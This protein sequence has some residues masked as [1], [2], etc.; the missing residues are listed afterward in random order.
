MAQLSYETL[1]APLF[2]QNAINGDPLHPEFG[3]PISFWIHGNRVE[4]ATSATPAPAQIFDAEGLWCAPGFFDFGSQWGIPG[5]E[6]SE[7]LETGWRAAVAGGFTESLV[8]PGALFPLDTAPAWQGFTHRYARLPLTCHV[9]AAI[10]AG[11]TG[12]HMAELRE[13]AG[14][15]AIAFS[16]G[17]SPITETGTLRLA[18]EYGAG[19][20]ALFIHQPAV[21]GLAAGGQVHE[22]MASLLTGLP[23]IPAEEEFLGCVRDLTVARYLQKPLHVQVISS[24]MALSYI[25][26]ARVP[27]ISLGTSVMHLCFDEHQVADFDSRFK[28]FPPLR[29]ATDRTALLNA[30]KEGT[31]QVVT[32]Q[33]RPVHA[34][35]KDR[36]FGAAAFGASGLETCFRALLNLRD[37]G[38]ELKRII[39]VLA[40]NPRKL[41]GLEV[42][43][44]KDGARASFTFFSLAPPS[45][46][47]PSALHSR[48]QNNP[49]L[50]RSL[51]GC[52]HAVYHEGNI[53]R[54]A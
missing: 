5:Q 28:I 30:V 38:L 27:G 34:D 37:E 32:A 29:A 23:G 54:T 40:V 48:S 46:V 18:L 3:K 2:V 10:T 45:Q 50:G 44:I 26:D 42:P 22:G 31:I 43:G 11:A 52:I 20:P 9:A 21:P 53:F 4:P 49:F 24:E 12:K 13:L 41:L 6:L 33:H 47:L 51:P 14:A 15:G 19:K 39:E 1:T 7:T 8:V 16:D 17:D 35:E 36:E 25:L